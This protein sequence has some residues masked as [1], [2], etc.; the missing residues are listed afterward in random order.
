MFGKLRRARKKRLEI[1]PGTIQVLRLVYFEDMYDQ[2]LCI[3]AYEVMKHQLR[4]PP[5]E[6]TPKRIRLLAS[7]WQE[8]ARKKGAYCFMY[9]PN[10][11]MNEV[12]R[13]QEELLRYYLNKN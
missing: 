8:D 2:Q 5:R 10:H 9:N 13:K 3:R 7:L 1:Q 6:I 4:W 11:D 12:M